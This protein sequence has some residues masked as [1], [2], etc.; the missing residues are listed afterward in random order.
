MPLSQQARRVFTLLIR[1]IDPDFQEEIELLLYNRGSEN[2]VWNPGDSLERLLAILCAIVKINVKLQQKKKKK[3]CMILD[4]DFLGM[5]IWITAPG[6]EPRPAEA[7]AEGRGN[8]ECV[9]GKASHL[10]NSSLM[11]DKGIRYRNKDA[12]AVCSFS[13][14]VMCVLTCTCNPFPSLSFF[15]ILFYI[16]VVGDNTL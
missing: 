5:K 6:K 8:M 15:L 9:V 13:L 11:E 12:G 2:C 14:L 4:L 16:Q 10:I 7:L 3:G 1:M